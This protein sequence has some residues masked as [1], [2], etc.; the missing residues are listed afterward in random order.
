MI[1]VDSKIKCM[2]VNNSFFFTEGVYWNLLSLNIVLNI[3]IDKAS[4]AKNKKAQENRV[5][6]IR[7]FQHSLRI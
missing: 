3:K 7:L 4:F 1:D 5:L 2:V 6:Q